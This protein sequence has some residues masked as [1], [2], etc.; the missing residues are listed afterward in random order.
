VE[1]LSLIGILSHTCKV[2]RPGGPFLRRLID[3]SLTVQRLDHFVHLSK[4][5][6]SDIEWWWQ[7]GRTITTQCDNTAV[8]EIV[9]WV[10]SRD[11][12]IH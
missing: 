4:E 1:L 9:N 3:L 2:V 12:V 10:S 11:K 7:Q 6:K 5:A 8:V